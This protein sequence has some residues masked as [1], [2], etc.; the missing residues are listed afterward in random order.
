MKRVDIWLLRVILR[1]TF[2]IALFGFAT[3]G[4]LVSLVTAT[5]FV[6]LDKFGRMISDQILAN[7]AIPSERE[8]PATAGQIAYSSSDVQVVG[9]RGEGLGC[10]LPARLANLA[11]P[12][13]D[14]RDPIGL[15]MRQ[16]CAAHD[17]CYRHGA[18]TYGYTQADCDFLLQEQAFRLCF[19]IERALENGAIDQAARSKCISDARLVTFGVRLGGSN[20]FR[21]LSPEI[22]PKGF[23]GQESVNDADVDDRASTYFEYDPYPVRSLSY[24]IFRIADAPEFRE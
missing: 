9:G 3:V 11:F 5:F 17:F 2:R 10:S 19:F 24:A 22:L 18:A 15:E 21:S 20:F 14:G 13:T 12:K 7:A 16:A 4:I 8:M 23:Y 1:K 6:R